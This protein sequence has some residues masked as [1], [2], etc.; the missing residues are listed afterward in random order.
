MTAVVYVGIAEALG[1]VTAG[2]TKF[3]SIFS[4]KYFIKHATNYSQAISLIDS[5]DAA[6]ILLDKVISDAELNMF[7][8]SDVDFTKNNLFFCRSAELRQLGSLLEAAEF[9]EFS[10]ELSTD[11]V[12]DLLRSTLGVAEKKIDP[13]VLSSI[14]VGI[15]QIFDEAYGQKLQ[16]RKVSF[17]RPQMETSDVTAICSFAGDGLQGTLVL[18]CGQAFLNKIIENLFAT[19]PTKIPLE[20]QVDVINEALNQLMGVV[21]GGLQSIGYDLRPSVIVSLR[22]DHHTHMLRA[23]GK[24]FNMPFL[25]G[26]FPLNLTLS[27]DLY[28]SN[29]NQGSGVIAK[30]NPARLFD[31]RFANIFADGISEAIAATT[32]LECRRIGHGRRAGFGPVKAKFMSFNHGCGKRLNY[33][34]NVVTDES[35]GRILA[36]KILYMPPEEITA[37]MVA[38]SCGEFFNQVMSHFRTKAENIGFRTRP[39]FHSDFSAETPFLFEAK[40]MA[41]A[42]RFTFQT[43]EFEFDALLSIECDATPALMD[44][45]SW[46][47]P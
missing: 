6:I 43:D 36:S 25:C 27:Y 4:K 45:Y 1:A 22:G 13:R 28:S 31:V 23:T 10:G 30:K 46:V 14:V 38:D 12:F 32:S 11:M 29:V 42:V 44:L 39:V 26:E 9:S 7:R 21:T 17:Q 41:R 24:F 37:D 8:D 18:S 19:D 5:Q 3:N 34:L 47:K 33:F 20:D 15:T 16:P 2:L 40:S 35:M